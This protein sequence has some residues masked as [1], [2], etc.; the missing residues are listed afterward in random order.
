VQINANIKLRVNGGDVEHLHIQRGF[1]NGE[2][3]GPL[4]LLITHPELGNIDITDMKVEVQFPE[5]EWEELTG[6][7]M[8]YKFLR[9]G[10]LTD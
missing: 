1:V 6:R 4:Q 10:I 5:E 8:L 2:P 3:K 7:N 9:L